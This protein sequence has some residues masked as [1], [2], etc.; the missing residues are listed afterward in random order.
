MDYTS[1]SEQLGPPYPNKVSAF[2]KPSRDSLKKVG[3][4]GYRCVKNSYKCRMSEALRQAFDSSLAELYDSLVSM[5]STKSM[6]GCLKEYGFYPG[7]GSHALRHR[8]A[9]CRWRIREWQNKRLVIF[10]SILKPQE[11]GEISCWK[12]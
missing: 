4:V 6:V 2:K 7:P 5:I 1:S 8:M 12:N 10:E 3:A 11:G 9:S